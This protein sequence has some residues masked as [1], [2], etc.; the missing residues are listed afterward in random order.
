MESGFLQQQKHRQCK[1]FSNY[2]RLLEGKIKLLEIISFTALV[3]CFACSNACIINEKQRIKQ[4]IIV[5]IETLT[6]KLNNSCCLV[7]KDHRMIPK[8]GFLKKGK[9][10]NFVP[11]PQNKANRPTIYNNWLYPQI[12]IFI[13]LIITS[14]VSS[15]I[16]FQAFMVQKESCSMDE[17][18]QVAWSIQSDLRLP[19][20]SQSHCHARQSPNV[21][22]A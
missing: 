7:N 21:L 3:Y 9:G 8:R 13:A 10:W 6:N 12:L 18:R 14:I 19:I 2:H 5:L 22:P 15:T 4:I 16:K 17:I 11:F 20:V 1:S